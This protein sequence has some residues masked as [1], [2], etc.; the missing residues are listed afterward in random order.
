MYVPIQ[1]STVHRWIEHGPGVGN[2][3][4]AQLV[5]LLETAGVNSPQILC[6]VFQLS[7]QWV[8]YLPP[9]LAQLCSQWCRKLLSCLGVH[10]TMD[11]TYLST[12]VHVH[13]CAPSYVRTYV[14]TTYCLPTTVQFAMNNIRNTYNGAVWRAACWPVL[15]LYF[16]SMATTTYLVGALEWWLPSLINNRYWYS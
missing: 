1:A 11:K 7:V 8:L 16:T 2:F 13:V 9:L 15:L 5:A 14:H 3:N 4:N 6:V 12:E 10:H